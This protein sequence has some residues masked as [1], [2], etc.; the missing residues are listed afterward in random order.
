MQYISPLQYRSTS[1]TIRATSRRKLCAALKILR[2]NGVFWSESELLRRLAKIYLRHWRGTGLKSAAA[3]RY[4]IGKTGVA[5]VRVAWYVDKVLHA[6]L[7][8]RAM[9]SGESISRMLD[10]AIRHYLPRLMEESL[11]SPMPGCARAARNH[12]Y[13]ESRF[14]CRF[15]PQPDLFI[16]YQCQTEQNSPAGLS[17]R[18]DYQIYRKT[19]LSAGDILYLM[20]HAA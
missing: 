9:H 5:Y 10:F 11:R 16:T 3:R 2:R 15:N 12:A 18:Q 19:G 4:N 17:Y 13:W 6:I 1:V 14:Q 8:Q 20:Q 7:W